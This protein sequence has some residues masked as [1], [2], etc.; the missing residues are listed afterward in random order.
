MSCRLC[1]RTANRYPILIHTHMNTLPY[2]QG[3]FNPCLQA[4]LILIRIGRGHR[5]MDGEI[6]EQR[7][8]TNP[9]MEIGYRSMCFVANDRRSIFSHSN[10]I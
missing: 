7:R 6:P 3:F 8:E 10:R 1:V 2:R 4:G 5:S 9:S